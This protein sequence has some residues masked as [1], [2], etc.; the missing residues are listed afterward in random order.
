MM[1]N[2][3]P[4]RISSESLLP[5]CARCGR[6]HEGRCVAG[7]EGC[8]SCGES[9]HKIRDCPMI[10]A[11]G[12]EGKQAAPSGSSVNAPKQNKLY[13]LQAQ[14]EQEC[15]PDVVTGMLKVF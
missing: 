13:A 2:P 12:K 7:T 14:G 11:K 6:R 9:G 10:K 1:S 3:R 8:F 5:T 4:Q 15:S